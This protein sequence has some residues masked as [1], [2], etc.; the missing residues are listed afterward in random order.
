[1]WTLARIKVPYYRQIVRDELK[2]THAG[3]YEINQRKY[4]DQE[5]KDIFQ[6]DY[7]SPSLL[8]SGIKLLNQNNI[9]NIRR[10]V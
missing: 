8:F 1:M 4:T 5:Y 3:I 10:K 9:K 2:N 6:H 7:P